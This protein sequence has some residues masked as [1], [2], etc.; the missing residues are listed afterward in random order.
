M[1]PV[2]GKRYP[3]LTAGLVFLSLSLGN[4]QGFQNR[5]GKACPTTEGVYTKNEIPGNWEISD[6]DWMDHLA[7]GVLVSNNIFFDLSKLRLY[8]PPR[9]ACLSVSRYGEPGKSGDAKP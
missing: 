9:G 1:G 7:L 8:P 6:Q 2:P 3:C 5:C 4:V